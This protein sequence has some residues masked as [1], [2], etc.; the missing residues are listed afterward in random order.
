M[1]WEAIGAVGEI[2]SAL[3]VL[4]TLIYLA[5]QVRHSRRE[6]QASA[7]RANRMERRE[8]HTALRDSPYI[9]II[10]VKIESGDELTAE[11]EHRLLQ[12]NAASWGLWYSEWIQTQLQSRGQFG[13]SQDNTLSYLFAQ[14]RSLEFFEQHGRRLYPKEFTEYVQRLLDEYNAQTSV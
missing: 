10:Y 6:Q 13:T 12:H 1:N 11:E 4:V 8:F 7:I 14:P 2:V 3:A 9:P 5:I